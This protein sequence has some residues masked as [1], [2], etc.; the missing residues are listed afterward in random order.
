MVN[1][2][3]EEDDTDIEKRERES[4]KKGLLARGPRCFHLG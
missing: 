4:E 1:R 3:S 2:K